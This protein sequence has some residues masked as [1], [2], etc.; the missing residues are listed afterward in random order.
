M[1]RRIAE[2]Q[3]PFGGRNEFPNSHEPSPLSLALALTSSLILLPVTRTRNK[4]A[5][6]SPVPAV[7]GPLVPPKLC[8]LE[9][10]KGVILAVRLKKLIT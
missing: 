6:K 8:D 4:R 2:I 7:L 5:D 10:P 3:V 1:A 9:Y